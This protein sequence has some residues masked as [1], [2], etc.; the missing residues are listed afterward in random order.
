MQIKS[1]IVDDEKHGREN[2]AGLLESHCPE[3]ILVGL[4]NSVKSAI[5]LIKNEKPQLV[6]LDIEM[7]G[8]NGFQLLEHFADINFEVIFVTAYD[9]YAIKAIRFSAADYIL[10]PIN[11]NELKTAVEKVTKR[12]QKKEENRQIRELNRNILQPDNP[13]IGLPTNDR[14]EFV[15]VKNI[16]HCKGES[17]YTHIYLHEKK[18]LLVAK[19]LVEFEDLLKEHSFVRTHKSHLV[20]LKHVVAYS[21]TDGGTLELSNGDKIFISRRRKDEVLKMLKTAIA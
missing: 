7:P 2:L 15:E 5:Q 16:V 14:I 12:I 8:E 11:F 17:N 4:A 21:K 13:R 1:I 18:H 19:T 10:K 9:N 6:F 20:N 3:V